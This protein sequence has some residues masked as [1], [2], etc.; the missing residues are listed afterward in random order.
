MAL[1][2]ITFILA[3]IAF[4]CH[5]LIF[6]IL[7]GV[8]YRSSSRLL[9]WMICAGGL[10]AAAQVGTLIPQL[11]GESKSLLQPKIGV[12]ILGVGLNI[13]GAFYLGVVG[14]VAA[15]IAQ[16]V[17]FLLWIILSSATYSRRDRLPETSPAA[18]L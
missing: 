9:P 5:D 7:V 4:I 1:I 6:K 11:Y 8:A 14:I 13:A 2:F 12:A 3:L 16:S 10:F 17:I 18:I 15:S